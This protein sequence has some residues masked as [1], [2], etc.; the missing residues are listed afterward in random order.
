MIHIISYSQSIKCSSVDVA[1]FSSLY[2]KFT[3]RLK[4]QSKYTNPED[5]II[6]LHTD[7]GLEISKYSLNHILT[8]ML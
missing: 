4:K 5:K 7:K 8:P 2:V 1:L 6:F 3:W